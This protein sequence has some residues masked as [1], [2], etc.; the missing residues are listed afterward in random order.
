MRARTSRRT[1]RAIAVMASL[2]GPL[3]AL[4][5]DSAL[6]NLLA[7]PGDVWALPAD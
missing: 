5:Q 7:N 3:A 2:T 1:F 6:G 4:S